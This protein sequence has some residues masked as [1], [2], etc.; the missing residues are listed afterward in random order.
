MTMQSR[1]LPYMMALLAGGITLGVV[2]VVDSSEQERFQESSQRSVTQKLGIVRA[3]L[4]GELNVRLFLTRGLV[5]YVS[6]HPDISMEEFRKTARVLLWEGQGGI[7]G[8]QLAKNTVVS[9]LY[10]LEGNEKAKGLRLLELPDQRAPVLRALETKRTVVAGPVNLVQG[11]VA[12]ISRTPIY[13]TP[14]G[15]APGSGPYWGLATI[16]IDTETLLKGAGLSD[17]SE[18]LQYALRGKDGLGAQGEVFFGNPAIFETNPVVLNVYLPNGS[19]QLA[20]TPIGGWEAFPRRSWIFRTGGGLLALMA[21]AVVFFVILYNRQRTAEVVGKSEQSLAEAQRVAHLGSYDWNIATNQI[22]A[23]EE[24]CRIFSAVPLDSKAFFELVHPDDR[25]AVREA[26]DRARNDRGYELNMEHRIVRID[27]TER[28]VHER[29]VVV[30]SKQGRPIRMLGTVQDIT[31]RKAAEL[32]AERDRDALRHMTRVSVLGQLSASIAHQLN[33]PLAAILANA[34]AAQ[35]MLARERWDITELREICKDIVSEDHRAAEVIGRLRAL[36][37][38]GDLKLEPLDVNELVRETLPLVR[39]DLVLHHVAL[40]LDL[41]PAL[42]EVDGDRVQLQQVLLNLVVNASDA[43]SDTA[44]EE[45]G[46]TIRTDANDGGV[47]ICVI[48][49]GPGIAA[50]DLKNVFDPFWSTKPG[51]T[52]MGLTIC[53]SILDVHNGTLAAANNPD[54]GAAF[55]AALPARPRA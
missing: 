45:R 28:I 17:T 40:N 30:F 16:L 18:G 20:A 15:G 37:K 8:I 32:Q 46:L 3:R 33:Q 9:H 34:E 1:L 39:T 38:R 51:N 44:W 27:A 23:S 14:L 25:K 52:G 29:A 55:C 47:R 4:E 2:W 24:A 41:A 10:P 21:G 50:A 31:E 7:R 43:M 12:F 54:G 49:R 19:W 5:G 11:G 26:V 36:F 48:D 53:R 22:T 13:L 35:K 42:P 6:T